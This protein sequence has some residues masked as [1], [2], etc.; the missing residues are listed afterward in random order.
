MATQVLSGKGWDTVK[1]KPGNR[2]SQYAVDGYDILAMDD[3]ISKTLTEEAINSGNKVV[4]VAGKGVNAADK[5][6]GILTEI[7]TYLSEQWIGKT[8]DEAM[9]NKIVI[10]DDLNKLLSSD[11]NDLSDVFI[12]NSNLLLDDK[13][14]ICGVHLE[15][16]G[17]PTIDVGKTSGYASSV[18]YGSHLGILTDP[19]LFSK[20]SFLNSSVSQ[21]I[22]D[23]F[24][25][26]EYRLKTTGVDTLTN[27]NLYFDNNGLL[28]S[29]DKKVPDSSFE[30]TIGDVRQFKSN[31]EMSKLFS[32]V[33][34]EK[35]SELE[36]LQIRQLE[37][38][39]RRANGIFDID[40][41]FITNIVRLFYKQK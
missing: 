9:A 16:D 23:E 30:T 5:K 6:V 22:L 4:Y 25:V 20:Y 27:K 15:M 36:K 8:V 13:R 12:R 28:L 32:D 24:R 26:G 39:Y 14:I 17:F 29:I 41:F 7:P 19:E 37:L 40:K 34:F 18:N 35:L 38:E 21:S 2:L 33:D 11:L 1:G 31:A 3:F 10:V